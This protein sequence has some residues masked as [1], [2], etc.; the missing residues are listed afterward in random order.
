MRSVAGALDPDFGT[1][2]LRDFAAEAALELHPTATGFAPRVGRFRRYAA[3][4]RAGSAAAGAAGGAQAIS[5]RRIR[6]RAQSS[7][8]AES[9]SA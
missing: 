8:A 7:S 9:P 6:R 4:C 1:S 3:R 2:Q 5:R